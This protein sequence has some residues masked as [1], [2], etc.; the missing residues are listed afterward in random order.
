MVLTLEEDDDPPWTAPPS[1]RRKETPIPGPLPESIELVVG[2][3]VY[4]AKADLPPGLRKSALLRST[5][6]GIKL[7]V[8]IALPLAV[9][10]TFIAPTLVLILG[11]SSYLPHAGIAL[12]IM[13]WS[14]P[15]GWI[16]SITNYV[17][18]ALGQQSKL[19]RAFIVL[20]LV[21]TLLAIPFAV[22][23]G[24]LPDG[25]TMDSTGAISGTPTTVATT[26]FTVMGEAPG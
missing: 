19:T 14:I 20:P 7:L 9:V 17:L 16:N 6:V 22:T 12:Q 4:V 10:T 24:S 5:Q 1:R 13:I 2:D 23:T 18:I 3:Q 11:G 26:T 21:M 25:L 8:M 15:F